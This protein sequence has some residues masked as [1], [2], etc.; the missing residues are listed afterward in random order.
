MQDKFCIHCY[1]SGLVQGVWYRAST[2]KEAQ[3]LGLTGW[4]R[5]LSDGRVEVLACGSREQVQALYE[6]LKVGPPR[7]KVTEV[8]YEEKNGEEHHSFEVIS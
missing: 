7:A 3:R 5:N 8:S 2:Q 4:V 6:W 1:V